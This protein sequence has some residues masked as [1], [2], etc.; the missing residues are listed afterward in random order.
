MVSTSGDTIFAKT[1][2][3]IIAG[4]GNSFSNNVGNDTIPLLSIFKFKK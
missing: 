2:E 3:D 4:R 1:N